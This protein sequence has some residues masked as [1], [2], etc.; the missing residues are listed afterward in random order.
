M[1][2]DRYEQSLDYAVTADMEGLV[3]T[4]LSK[5]P[6][7]IDKQNVID[8]LKEK[9]TY[10]KLYPEI[11]KKRHEEKTAELNKEIDALASEVFP[12][13]P[14]LGIVKSNDYGKMPSE[15]TS[16][17]TCVDNFNADCRR[18][19]AETIKEKNLSCAKKVAA[20]AKASIAWNDL[21]DWVQVVEK[22]KDHS[23]WYEAYKVIDDNSEKKA[24]H[25]LLNEA[26]RNGSFK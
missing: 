13:R 2:G 14:A 22:H 6:S 10:N 26:I 3:S 11:K 5:N 19:L 23:S 7:C 25:Q 1:A 21:G 9:G 20:M 17:R 18:L 4:F 8:Y 16:Y 24:I 15:Y 12:T